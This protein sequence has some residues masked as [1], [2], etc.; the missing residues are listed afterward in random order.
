MTHINESLTVFS[1][2][3]IKSLITYNLISQTVPIFDID[4]ANS[5]VMESRLGILRLEFH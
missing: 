2:I 1:I 3:F 5:G 4:A